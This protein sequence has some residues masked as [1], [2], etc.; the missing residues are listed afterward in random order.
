[1]ILLNFATAIKGDSVVEGH[2]DW[3][4]I[5]SFQMGAGRSIS[6]SGGGKDR[7]TSNPSISEVT[8]TKSMDQ[9]ST[10]LFIQA[11]CGKSLGKATIDFIQTGGTDAKDQIFLQ[12]ELTDA[13]ISSYSVSSGGDR[14]SESIAIN[15]TQIFMKYNAF[16]GTTV[17]AGSKKGWDLMKNQYLTG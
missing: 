9:A 7:E 12:Y 2:T 11:I 3:I 10:D 16:S 5:D 14:P 4:T 13:I 8:L 6:S 17:T 15:F 1:M